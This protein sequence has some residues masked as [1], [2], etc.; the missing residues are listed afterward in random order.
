VQPRFL[1]EEAFEVSPEVDSHRRG[2]AKRYRSSQRR[3]PGFADLPCVGR[4]REL[5]LLDQS[6]VSALGGHGSSWVITGPPGIG[7]S[8]LMRRI[9]ELGGQRGFEVRN[10]QALSGTTEPLFPL[11]QALGRGRPRGGADRGRT[12]G[13][14][15][16]RTPGDQNFGYGRQRNVRRPAGTGS[17][18][19]SGIDVRELEGPARGRHGDSVDLRLLSLLEEL[20][21][22]AE[23]GPQ[24]LLLDDFH[25]ADAESLRALRLM[26]RR[27]HDRRVMVVVAAIAEPG[28]LDETALGAEL[29]TSLRSGMLRT[30]ELASLGEEASLRLAAAVA[31]RSVEATRRIDGIRSVIERVG[32]TPYFLVEMVGAFMERG[33][34][35]RPGGPTRVL[36]LSSHPDAPPGGLETPAT[37]RASILHRVAALPVSD[38]KL[39]E[40]AAWVGFQFDAAALSAAANCPL[41]T[42][43]RRLGGLARGGWPLR[44]VDYERQ[45]YGFEHSLLHATL[46][47]QSAGPPHRSIRRLARWWSV[48]RA[49]DPA[50]EARLRLAI[51]DRAEAMHCLERAVGDAIDRGA[52]RSVRGILGLA[53]AP[54]AATGTDSAQLVQLYWR[55]AARLRELWEMDG[56]PSLLDDLLD[57]DVPPEIAW[58]ARCWRLECDYRHDPVGVDRRVRAL[59][60]P[61]R[62][63]STLVPPEARQLLRYLL[64]ISWWTAPSPT[65]A[66]RRI[67]RSREA[68]N[69]GHHDFEL[70]RLL[71]SHSHMLRDRGRWELADQAL[72]HARR[73]LRRGRLRS[74]RLGVFVLDA[75]ASLDQAKGNLDRGLRA[76]RRAVTL[77]RRLANPSVEAQSLV[78]LGVIEFGCRDIASAAVHFRTAE[79]LMIKLDN[80]ILSPYCASMQ[81]WC[82]VVESDWTLA[83]R[84]FERAR[85]AI[86]A[87]AWKFLDWHIAT[88]LG[89]ALTMQGHLE[90]G[91][92]EFPPENPNGIESAMFGTEY[93]AC[94]SRLLEAEGNLPGARLAL[95][96]GLR[97]ARRSRHTTDLIEA[98][99]QLIGWERRHGSPRTLERWRSRRDRVGVESR[100]DIRHQWKAIG[101]GGPLTHRPAPTP[102]LSVE[103]TRAH[104]ATAALILRFVGAP[105]GSPAASPPRPNWI[106][107][108]EADLAVGVG[109]PRSAIAR[110]LGRLRERGFLE[111]VSARPPGAGRRVFVYRL[112]NGGRTAAGVRSDPLGR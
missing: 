41:P 7:K 28:R 32:G 90:A 82:A 5:A 86:P 51:G 36:P 48:H 88:G 76:A 85:Q 53:R 16:S 106:G 14:S 73:V 94:R 55:T 4:D 74:P 83:Q 8:R 9:A 92:R 49:Q 38:R 22:A 71:V 31:G 99:T 62:S 101:L 66:E 11:L 50:T 27:V 2:G 52:F 19:G 100:R 45:R 60:T 81:G 65:V 15:F 63:A 75:A 61:G 59:L 23:E 89:L 18:T 17:G 93:H 72:R 13:S 10:G 37:V 44:I 107:V 46:L 96:D 108:S 110:T 26:I 29:H 25:H 109:L 42:V 95:L 111:R 57:L 79:E 64:A 12:P 3:R 78:A 35:G 34:P 84:S 43:T 54:P 47:E 39:L 1:P 105:G 20:E 104:G 24:L 112:T 103:R 97:A 98:Y 56:L 6:L 69:D 21:G 68:M 77:S 70:F 58:S 40:L 91:R 33:F 80:A 102:P 87:G 67:R 30:L